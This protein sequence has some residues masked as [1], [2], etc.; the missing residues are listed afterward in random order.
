MKFLRDDLRPADKLD[1]AKQL[2]DAEECC[3][4][5][6]TKWARKAYPTAEEFVCAENMLILEKIF[7]AAPASN[8][9]AENRFS[10]QARQA[11]SCHGNHVAP[12]AVATSHV[13][14]EAKTI[15]DTRMA[16]GA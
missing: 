9:H 16:S 15:L 1:L 5:P 12:V 4:D 3:L 14:G 11:V 13:L 8:V 10:R 6:F 7:A 2:Y